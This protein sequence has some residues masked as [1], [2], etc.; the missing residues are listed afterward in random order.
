MYISEQKMARNEEL[1]L[2]ILKGDR[3]KVQAILQNAINLNQDVNELLEESMIPAMREVGERFARNEIYVPEMLISARAMQAGL[4]LIE[5]ILAKSNHKARGKVA[6]G[7]VK[8]DLHDIGK[9]LVS[10]MLKGA[11][12]EVLDLG[13]N[14][15]VEKYAEA[16]NA[17]TNILLCSALLTTTMMYM[18]EI[19]DYFKS[20]N[21]VKI[22]VGGAPVT[23]NFADLIG[24]HAY[25]Q[26]ANDAVRI[27]ANLTGAV[28]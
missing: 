27:V 8:G 14:C 12:Y 16:V 15:S 10:I 1:Y 22:V 4:T 19:V 28:V 6:I 25:G 13:V 18:K 7:T 24:A 20:N 17:G 3:A 9:N 11:G 5:P 26:N 23:Q 21:A 2:A